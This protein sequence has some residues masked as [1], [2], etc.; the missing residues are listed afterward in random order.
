MRALALDE[1]PAWVTWKVVAVPAGASFHETVK[2]T[3]FWVAV[4]EWAWAVCGVEEVAWGVGLVWERR[5]GVGVDALLPV[6][7]AVASAAVVPPALFVLATLV[8][9]DVAALSSTLSAA[10][11]VLAPSS[12]LPVSLFEVSVCACCSAAA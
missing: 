6:V 4:A 7:L 5:D 10:A 1:P 12:A 9:V 3:P 2:V 11:F 8:P